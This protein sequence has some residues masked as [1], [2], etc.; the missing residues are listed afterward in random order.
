[1][2][3]QAAGSP[4]RK[5]PAWRAVVSCVDENTY[6]ARFSSEAADCAEASLDVDG[7]VLAD[8][9][10]A[11]LAAGV[12]GTEATAVSVAALGAE[13]GVDGSEFNGIGA[14]AA[15]VEAALEVVTGSGVLEGGVT[16]AVAATLERVEVVLAGALDEVAATLGASGA[17]GA[18]LLDRLGA[19]AAVGD[20]GALSALV[21]A[22]EGTSV[23]AGALGAAGSEVVLLATCVAGS[24]KTISLPLRFLSN[25]RA[26][27]ITEAVM[28]PNAIPKW[29][30]GLS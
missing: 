4:K 3:S 25:S 12:E 6:C 19:L 20:L 27:P 2:A 1:M 7:A 29:F 24:G 22:V 10:L 13:G 14:G 15:V 16:R 8:C 23:A 30:M 28:T 17:F 9:V 26:P 21:G 5:R 18:G 11:A